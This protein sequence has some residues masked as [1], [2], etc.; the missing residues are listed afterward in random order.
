MKR[1]TILQHG[2]H[3]ACFII[4]M[5]WN[6]FNFRHGPKW[7]THGCFG[8][9]RDESV[10]QSLKI[11]M[12][13][14]ELAKHL[15]PTQSIRASIQPANLIYLLKLT[16]FWDLNSTSL[17]LRQTENCLIFE[18]SFSVFVCLCQRLQN[19]YDRMFS[20]NQCRLLDTGEEYFF[21]WI[22]IIILWYI[23]ICSRKC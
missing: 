14:K 23:Y 18:F 13:L 21:F 5:T 16:I 15:A 2:A 7:F 22:W 1:S 6:D 17:Q 11:Y 3:H 20:R 4:R 10:G 8:R 12:T 19:I 9:H